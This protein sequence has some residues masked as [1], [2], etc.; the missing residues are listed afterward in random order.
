MA[1]PSFTVRPAIDADCG[2]F[3][4]LAMRPDVRN[5]SVR[6]EWFSRE[7]HDEW[8]ARRFNDPDTAMYVAEVDGHV[9]GHVRY[10]KADAEMCE[11]AISI[12]PEYRGKGY[13]TQLLL[14]TEALAY[15]RLGTRCAVALVLVHNTA[16]KKTFIRAG[17]DFQ[18]ITERMGKTVYR[19]E[20]VI[21]PAEY[22]GRWPWE[23][24][25]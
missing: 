21:A 10:G 3:Y 4:D 7:E 8:W 20:K 15:E 13:G 24:H 19:Y 25:P 9:V 14:A 6:S 11:L 22:E 12:C 16:S 2:W 1:G 5:N 17:Y 23:F 18:W